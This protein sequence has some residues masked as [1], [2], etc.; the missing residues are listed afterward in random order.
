MVK[1]K[2]VGNNKLH[3]ETTNDIIY[4]KCFDGQME[5]NGLKDVKNAII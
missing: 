1:E 4:V 5:F 2:F 3:M